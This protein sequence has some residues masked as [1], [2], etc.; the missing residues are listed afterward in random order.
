VTPNQCETARRLALG[1]VSDEIVSKEFGV[2]LSSEPAHTAKFLAT[3]AAQRDAAA[4]EAALL[5]AFHFGFTAEH[6]PVLSQLVTLDWHTRH[7]DVA[8]AL[9]E[10]RAPESIQGLYEAASKTYRA[11]PYLEA[12]GGHSFARKCTWAL[13]RINTSEAWQ[14]LELLSQ[15][16]DGQVQAY[17]QKR[18]GERT[19]KVRS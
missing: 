19:R 1:R 10:L 5:L 13:A 12:D 17:A 8:V 11:L 9:E 16:E 14:K 4:V 15:S 18:L 3:A 7:Q 2:D 6:V